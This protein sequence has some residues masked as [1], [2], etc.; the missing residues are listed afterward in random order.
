MMIVTAL[1]NGTVSIDGDY[2]RVIYAQE[3]SACKTEIEARDKRN[4]IEDASEQVLGRRLTLRASIV[5][6][7]DGPGIS[8]T[9]SGG[10]RVPQ[11]KEKSKGGSE[12]DPK[13]QALLDKF[14]GEVIEVIKPE[15]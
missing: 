12:H 1:D 4:A 6:Q 9:S 2:L 14:H 7:A 15:Q 3:N 5:G 8:T 10:E 11:R 13:L